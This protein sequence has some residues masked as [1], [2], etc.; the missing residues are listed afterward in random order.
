MTSKLCPNCKADLE[1]WK[2]VFAN[3]VDRGRHVCFG[4]SELA[5]TER[6]YETQNNGKMP[7]VSSKA[8]R[9]S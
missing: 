2:E 5:R 6:K 1:V 8:Q 9:A 4:S 3:D 7:A